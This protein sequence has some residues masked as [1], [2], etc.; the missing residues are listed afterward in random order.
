MADQY[1]DSNGGYIKK[2][3]DA[4]PETFVWVSK[5]AP[6]SQEW[7]EYLAWVDRGNEILPPPPELE[8]VPVSPVI[9]VDAEFLQDVTNAGSLADVKQ[10]ILDAAARAQTTP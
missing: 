3:D 8:P 4:D 7:L 1:Q 9:V 2:Y 5:D 6:D 10:A